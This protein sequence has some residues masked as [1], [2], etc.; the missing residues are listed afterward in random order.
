MMKKPFKQKSFKKKIGN[1]KKR[2][3][4]YIINNNQI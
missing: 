1:S 2:L 3:N 4:I